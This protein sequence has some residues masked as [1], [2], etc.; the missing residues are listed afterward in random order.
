MKYQVRCPKCKKLQTYEPKRA[1]MLYGYK[2]KGKYRY[3]KKKCVRCGNTFIIRGVYTDR[4]KG[5]KEV[6][7]KNE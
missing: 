1:G 5:I 2:Y 7:E 4:I 3:R 6:K